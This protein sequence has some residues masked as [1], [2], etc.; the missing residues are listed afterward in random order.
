MDTNPACWGLKESFPRRSCIILL[1]K[2]LGPSAV[3]NRNRGPATPWVV[4]EKVRVLMRGGQEHSHRAIPLVRS[5]RCAGRVASIAVGGEGGRRRLIRDWWGARVRLVECSLLQSRQ[6]RSLPWE[7]LQRY[8]AL[9][10]GRVVMKRSRGRV[11]GIGIAGH[12]HGRRCA[13]RIADRLAK[14]SLGWAS[15]RS[16][17]CNDYGGLSG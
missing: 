8:I 11:G 15:I 16:G 6:G 7:N 4:R 10:Q 14:P 1:L 9:E 3:G 5:W 2:K 12:C 13:R 17:H